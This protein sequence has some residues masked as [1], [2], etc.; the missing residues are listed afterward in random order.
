[1][2]TRL[3]NWRWLSVFVLAA[4]GFLVYA[5][6]LNIGFWYDDYRLIDV[7][8]RT[9][10]GEYLRIYFDPRLPVYPFYRPM[11]GLEWLLCFI[12]FRGDAS[13]YHWVQVALHVMGTIFLFDSI[14]QIARNWRLAVIAALI[15]LTLP[16]TG[17][18]FFGRVFLIPWLRSFLFWRFVCGLRT[19]NV[20][21][22]IVRFGLCLHLLAR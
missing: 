22:G 15:Y 3:W 1:M 13:G 18:R 6:S 16:G 5:P 14:N 2:F 11:K 12:V 9:S 4:V 10:L 17:W 20:Q 21:Y 7:A 8:G 19:C